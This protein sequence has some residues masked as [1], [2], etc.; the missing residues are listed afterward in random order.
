MNHLIETNN[1]M[2][3]R[4]SNI[5]NS[6]E[7]S[8]VEGLLRS[9]VNTKEKGKKILVVG[10]GRSGLVARAFAMRL[11]HLGFDAHVIGETI[12]PKFVDGDLCLIISGSGRT[13]I[14]VAVSEMARKLNVETIIITSYPDS[15]VGRLATQIVEIPGR[16]D[17]LREKEYF[18]SLLTG[19]HA[20]LRSMSTL[21]ENACSLF[22]DGVI[23]ELIYRLDITTSQ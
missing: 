4:I 16:V 11:V 8:Q 14:S 3:K 15:P 6:L 18:T 13:S 22:L 9:L 2:L 1:E 5:L 23:S 20:P 10:V 12:T 21:F 7:K 19:Q 17:I